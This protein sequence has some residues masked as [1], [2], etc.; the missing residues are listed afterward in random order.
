M[1][2]PGFT[3]NN[4]AHWVRAVTHASSEDTELICLISERSSA[5]GKGRGI[6]HSLPRSV[7]SSLTA[8][9]TRARGRISPS[10]PPSPAFT[11]NCDGLGWALL[12]KHHAL[13]SKSVPVWA[14]SNH[15]TRHFSHVGFILGLT[16]VHQG[17]LMNVP[18]TH[19][20][21]WVSAYSHWLRHSRHHKAKIKPKPG[22]H[23]LVC[24]LL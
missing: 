14:P 7:T 19:G 17:I 13:S 18:T 15:R 6:L 11:H 10:P 9:G 21:L 23:E 2:S 16:S 4:R 22:S 3:W 12:A 20:W 1:E 24:W 5:L 8:A